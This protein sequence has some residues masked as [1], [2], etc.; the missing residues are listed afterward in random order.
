MMTMLFCSIFTGSTELSDFLGVAALVVAA[1]AAAYL[2]LFKRDRQPLVVLTLNCCFDA[3]HSTSAKWEQH[4]PQSARLDTIFRWLRRPVGRRSTDDQPAEVANP[5]VVCLQEIHASSLPRVRRFAE[6]NNLQMLCTLYNDHPRRMTYLVTLVAGSHKVLG[7]SSHRVPG[8]FNKSL[9]VDLQV[10]RTTVAVTNVHLPLGATDP[11]ERLAA[12]DFAAYVAARWGSPHC[13]FCYSKNSARACFFWVWLLLQSCFLRSVM[14]GDWNTLPEAGRGAREQIA[15]AY[16]R[17][18]ADVS[19][20]DPGAPFVLWPFGTALL[21]SFVLPATNPL[22][23]VFFAV[24]SVCLMCCFF[25]RVHRWK[26]LSVP[27]FYGFPNEVPRLQGLQ[28]ECQLDR[29][30]VSAGVLVEAF[31]AIT[32]MDLACTARECGFEEGGNVELDSRVPASDHLPVVVVLDVGTSWFG[33]WLGGW[34]AVP[35]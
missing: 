32:G 34:L 24:A 6:E 3:V 14:I 11:K 20:F 28:E 18:L 13:F 15:L 7:S 5:D 30:A 35:V 31:D 33:R 23:G 21:L 8:G 12:T 27:T 10:G 9:S 17:G 4:L 19:S 16:R 1:F 29:A 2:L 26:P 22:S 25:L